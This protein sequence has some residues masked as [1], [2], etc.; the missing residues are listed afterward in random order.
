MSHEPSNKSVRRI[1]LPSGRSIE[2]IRSAGSPPPTQEPGLHICPECTSH[3]V[4]PV[5][6]GEGSG[7]A[8]EM[9]LECPNCSWTLDGVFAREQVNRFEEQLDAGLATMLSDLR[10]LAQANMSE[11]VERFA[12]ALRDDLILPEDF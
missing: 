12:T 4:Q 11:E 2:V 8:W 5:Q 7:G 3:L 9:T 10:R 1:V 6:W